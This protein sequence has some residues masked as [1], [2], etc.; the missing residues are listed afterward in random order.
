M[1]VLLFEP[2]SKI[3]NPFSTFHNPQNENFHIRKKPLICSL[4]WGA[5]DADG[6]K[7]AT[8]TTIH[9][10]KEG[11]KWCTYETGKWVQ[12]VHEFK[13]T[14]WAKGRE[15]PNCKIMNYKFSLQHFNFMNCHRVHLL[16]PFKRLPHVVRDNFAPS[17][18]LNKK[19]SLLTQQKKIVRLKSS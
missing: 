18:Y 13:E 5:C 12:A 10:F 17:Y 19:T 1:H 16:L 7:A 15:G 4:Q 3:V 9:V 8:E 2:I 11:R 14:K 6:E